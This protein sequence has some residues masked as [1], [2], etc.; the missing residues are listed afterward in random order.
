MWTKA[1]KIFYAALLV[2]KIPS[3]TK[4]QLKGYGFSTSD[5]GTIVKLAADF[6]TGENSPE[7]KIAGC[8]TALKNLTSNTL[9]PSINFLKFCEFT[10]RL[11]ANALSY[12]CNQSLY[13]DSDNR[14]PIFL[15]AAKGT[16]D[17]AEQ[18]LKAGA[19]VDVHDVYGYT[20][21]TLACINNNRPVATAFL[22]HGAN[23]NCRDKEGSAPLH[24]AAQLGH[25]ALFS[26]LIDKGAERNITSKSGVTPFWLAV[27]A[28]HFDSARILTQEFK[29][30][31]DWGDDNGET[32]L[33]E[34]CRK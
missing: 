20:P 31:V 27:L 5:Y 22:E 9:D 1:H 19:K 13:K 4:R 12:L 26:L 8:L 18:L 16:K 3:L 17:D 34:A 33:Q 30:I 10:G 2:S 11:N 6:K 14:S 21:L 32:P 28:G 24:F 29:C 23:V 15:I 25:S 7:D